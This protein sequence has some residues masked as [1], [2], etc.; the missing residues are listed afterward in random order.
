MVSETPVT[1]TAPA[2]TVTRSR[3]RNDTYPLAFLSLVALFIPLYVIGTLLSLFGIVPVLVLG[4]SSLFGI[5]PSLFLAVSSFLVL[6]V[7][8]AG[9]FEFTC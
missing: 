3:N 1:E 8:P 2:E 7:R 5:A 4:L 9:V 6:F